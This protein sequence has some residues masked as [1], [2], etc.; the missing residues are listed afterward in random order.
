MRNTDII[1]IAPLIWGTYRGFYKGFISEL[2][3][4]AAMA[5]VFYFSVKFYPDV[6]DLIRSN[7]HTKMTPGLLS[8]VAFIT[9]FLVLYLIVFLI[10]LKIEGLTHALH[11]SL[12]NHLLGGVFGLLKWAFMIS[13]VIA[14]LGVFSRGNEFKLIKFNHSWL[15]N[16]IEVIAPTVMP[17]LLQKSEPEPEPAST[18]PPVKTRKPKSH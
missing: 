4:L 18:A 2:T 1:L 11:I 15:Y 5:V 8:I 13:I 14:L 9:L 6:A 17:D 7:F 10:T 12:V 16:H 3:S